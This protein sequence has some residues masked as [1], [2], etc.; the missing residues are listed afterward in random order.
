MAVSTPACARGA[1]GCEDFSIYFRI[2]E[3]YDFA[4]VPE[5]LTGYRTLPGNMSS[6]M[7]QMLRSWR[8]VADE[9]VERH[10]E[11]RAAITEGLANYLEWCALSAA[12][13]GDV[14]LVWRFCLDLV[15]TSPGQALRLVVGPL[16]RRLAKGARHRLGH[17][18]RSKT[19]HVR[20]A[21][22][23]PDRAMAAG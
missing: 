13:R 21:I 9:M 6:D 2:A 23:D 15:G 3:K 8:I 4:L 7:L 12:E 10:P 1:Q 16:P 19:R 5:P 17:S 22:G 20:F 14:T 11:S 18:P